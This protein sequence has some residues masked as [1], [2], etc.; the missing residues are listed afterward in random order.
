MLTNLKGFVNKQS[1]LAG[2]PT[3]KRQRIIKETQEDGCPTA[4]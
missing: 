2:V 4:R 3:D 1:F